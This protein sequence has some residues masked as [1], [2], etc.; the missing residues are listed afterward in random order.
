MG[1][2]G[3]PDASDWRRGP[4]SAVV[5][6][7]QGADYLPDCLEALAALDP[8]PDEVIVVDDGSTD[9]S[10]ALLA[11]RFPGVRA[12]PLGTNRGPCAARN[13]G[14]AAARHR[15]VLLVDNDAVPRPD[16]LGK[17]RAALAA[18]PDAC[19]A[20]PRSVVFDE[21]ST[22]HYDGARL[23]YAGLLALRNFYRPLAEAEGT[24]V[25][26]VDGLV[27]LTALVDRDVVLAAGG[28]D[29][30]LFY[31]ME[32]Y[33]LALRLRIAGHALLSVEDALVL[34]RGG[35]PGLSLRAAREGPRYPVRRAYYHARN[36]WLILAKCHAL[37]T[38]VL[39]APALALYELVWLAFAAAK[40]NLGPTL[41]GK[42]DA[43]RRLPGLRARR[44][45]V[46]AARRTRDRDLLVGGPL[47]LTPHLVAKP[48]ARALAGALD[49]ALRAWWGLVR[50]LCG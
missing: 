36:R 2:T 35:T 48:A 14:L 12:L 27:A 41:R 42:L 39:T 17:L 1:A 6:N 30:E 31:L 22:V 34:H 3:E 15:A 50:P 4:V 28:F 13:A 44:R 18:R 20:Q 24:G 45:A 25:V 19:A 33:D 29:E 43:L 7:Y 9:G 47:T 10:L 11:A 16:V 8:G 5:I 32:D 40:G 49:L 37:R 23:H 26:D 38:L 21:P 46:Q